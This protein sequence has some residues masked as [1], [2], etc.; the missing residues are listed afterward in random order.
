MSTTD[1]TTAQL[2]EETAELEQASAGTTPEVPVEDETPPAEQDEGQETRAG[3]PE[4][5]EAA[6]YRKR[7]R[8]V[9]AENTALKEQLTALRR[10]E[11]ERLTGLPK[12]AALWAAGTELEDLL[13]DAGVVDPAKVAAAV[14][15]ARETLGMTLPPAPSAWGQGN[16]GISI[17]E[18]ARGTRFEDAFAPSSR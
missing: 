12:P 15:V 5:R 11:V 3:S 6:K 10:A 1:D 8:E 2:V 9:E 16:V 4:A 17:H 18:S 7:L 13:D 14:E